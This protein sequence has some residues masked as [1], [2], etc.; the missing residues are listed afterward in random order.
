MSAYVKNIVKYSKLDIYRICHLYEVGDPGIQ[1]AIK[2][3]LCAGKRNGGKSLEQDYREA[4]ASI[5]RAIEMIHE[6]AAQPPSI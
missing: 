5:Q 2:K 4:I 3:L 1:H 6:D